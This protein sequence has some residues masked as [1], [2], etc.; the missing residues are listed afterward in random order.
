MVARCAPINLVLLH[1]FDDF[2]PPDESHWFPW[3]WSATCVVEFTIGELRRSKKVRT[4]H[5]FLGED[6]PSDAD[7]AAGRAAVLVDLNRQ[8]ARHGFEPPELAVIESEWSYTPPT[9]RSYAFA[10]SEPF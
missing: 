3:A 1:G 9:Q 10:A 7:L 2:T 5:T 8:L 6:R 4:K